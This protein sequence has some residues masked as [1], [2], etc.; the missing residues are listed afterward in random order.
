MRSISSEADARAKRGSILTTD[1]SLSDCSG[2]PPRSLRDRTIERRWWPSLGQPA[3]PAVPAYGKSISAM[4]VNF[5]YLECAVE[6][7][8]PT[9][10]TY[11]QW[12]LCLKKS[13]ATEGRSFL[14]DA[15]N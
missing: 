9:K 14:S 7:S 12:Q 2:S 6:C 1:R 13:V 8:R 4:S 3:Q 11:G 5:T 15:R 10:T